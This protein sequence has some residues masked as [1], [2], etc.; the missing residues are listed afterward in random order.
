MDTA[1][2]CPKCGSTNT[3]PLLFTFPLAKRDYGDVILA[4]CRCYGDDRDPDYGCRDSGH[5]WWRDDLYK[6]DESIPKFLR[7]Y[8][9]K[10]K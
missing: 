2:K 10:N 7:D 6:N 9:S 1:I 5:W 8:M 3:A 4:G